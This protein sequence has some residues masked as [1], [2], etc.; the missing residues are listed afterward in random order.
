MHFCNVNFLQRCISILFLVQCFNAYSEPKWQLYNNKNGVSVYYQS[1]SDNTFEVRGVVTVSNVNAN[2]FL[3]L[4]SDTNTAPQWIENASKVNVIKHLSP[5]ENLVYSYFDSPWPVANRDVITYSCYSQLTPTQSQL[6]VKARADSLPRAKGVVRVITLNAHWLLTK[7]GNDLNIAYQIY[8][9][10]GGS[11]PTWLNN[12]V[13]LK[14]THKTLVNLRNIL[15]NKE[16]Q[17]EPPII[18][19]GQC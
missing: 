12:K 18:K 9:L 10:P 4:L 5:S 6:V 11:I 14:S 1:H 7:Q 8:A 15:I 13:G 19:A 17:A 16:Y 3:E 2:D